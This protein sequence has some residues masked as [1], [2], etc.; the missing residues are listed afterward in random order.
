MKSYQYVETFFCKGLMEVYQCLSAYSVQLSK[1]VHTEY[2]DHT[3]NTRKIL[4][5]QHIWLGLSQMAS[6]QALENSS[7]LV[8]AT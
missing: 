7:H 2:T 4:L 3:E 1:V 6:I 5:P 8:A